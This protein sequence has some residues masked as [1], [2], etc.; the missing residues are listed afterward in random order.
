MIAVR[1]EDGTAQRKRRWKEKRGEN[2]AAG[3]AAWQDLD[4]LSLKKVTQHPWTP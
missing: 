2:R 4:N 3:K 1:E